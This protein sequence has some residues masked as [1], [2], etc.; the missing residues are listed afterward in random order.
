MRERAWELVRVELDEG[1]P[2]PELDG[3]DAVVVMGGP[4]GAYEGDVHP[5]LDAEQRLLRAAVTGGTPVFGVCLGAQLLAAS[6][7]ARVYQGEEPEVGVLAVE[8]TAEGLA[9]PVTGALPPTFPSLQW[10][11]DTFDLPE[12]AVRLASS[13]AY[14]NQAFR[15]GELAYAVQFHL[16]VTDSMAREWGE[17]PAYANALESVRGPGALD[18]LLADFAEHAHEMR[19]HARTMFEQWA[20]LAE[21]AVCLT[22]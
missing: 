4:M 8:L 7:G 12:N 1:E 9:D 3:F 19:G 21:R 18:R 6:A 16:E 17:V 13:P 2:L 11:S 22:Q 20:V 10:H 15:I 14:E 5:W